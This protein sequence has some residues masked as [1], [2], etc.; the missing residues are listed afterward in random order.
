MNANAIVQKL[1][2]LCTVLRKDGITYQQ[3]VTEL[4]YLLFLKM[5]AE[6]NRETGSLPKGMRWADIVAANGLAK[7][8]H[9]RKI[10]VTLSATTTRL[11]KDDALILPPG[12]SVTPDESNRYANAQPLP[13]LVQKIFDGAS[14]FLREPQ[15]L[16]A[17]V[18]AIDELDWFSEERDQFGDI[19]EG[20]LQ[21]NAEET[22]RGAGQYF[23]PRVLIELLVRLMQPKPGEAIQDPAAGTGGF[24]I[25]ADRYMRARTDDYLNL[26]ERERDFQKR[27]A[28]RG[29]E[30]V[31]GTLRLLLMNLYLHD[32]DSDHI[33]LGD[34]LSDKG[35]GL[36][37]ADLI[38]TNPPFG[39]AGGATTRDDL[40]VTASV[41]SYQLPFVEHCIRALQPG[42]RA[43]IVVPDNVLFEDGRGRQLRQMMMDWCDL[44]T[45]L[46]LPTGIFYA[47]GV[48]TNV[49]FLTRGRAQIGN[50]K[51]VWIYDLRALM[52]KFGKTAPLMDV[53]FKDFEQ[54]FGTDPYGAKRGKDEGE[55]G[56]WRM[57][58]REEIARRSDN[59]DITWLREAEEEAEERLTE[60]DDIAA[61]ILGHLQA[62]T[63]EIE[64]LMGELG[65]EFPEV[66]G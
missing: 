36:G 46:R 42:G 43:A 56:R 2:R 5:M 62:A 51:S 27:Q 66:A 14:T 12:G 31:P 26:G 35:K 20:L 33:D 32:I 25:A 16:T 53:H 24:L 18:T 9:Y 11:G 48:K 13:D 37:R 4:T 8:E 54:A 7:L 3:Y 17:L 19:Y 60:P 22:K 44:H 57:F 23:T 41:A 61:A 59:L 45:I 50:T 39:P 21:K 65:D 15:N 30:N 58:K 47:Q 34:T 10:L 29:M 55:A 6:R 63:L 64:T 38:L 40:S 28:I 49:I 52:P 1:W